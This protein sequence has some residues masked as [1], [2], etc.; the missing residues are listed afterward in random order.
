MSIF[1]ISGFQGLPFFLFRNIYLEED[2]LDADL[3]IF[4]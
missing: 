3:N 1:E 4:D 2:D